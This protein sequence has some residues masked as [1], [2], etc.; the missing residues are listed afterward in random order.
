MIRNWLW[1][2][3]GPVEREG[4]NQVKMQGWEGR[5]KR[6]GAATGRGW[7]NVVFCNSPGVCPVFF[8]LYSGCLCAGHGKTTSDQD[9]LR[10]SQQ[11]RAL[12]SPQTA[13]W[14][15]LF[16][17][18]YADT[19]TRVFCWESFN[20]SNHLGYLLSFPTQ[21][22]LPIVHWSRARL[23]TPCTKSKRYT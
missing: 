17:H 23:C 9:H 6:W 22:L 10:G 20:Q 21:K 18:G 1:D 4:E 5:E 11:R 16:V 14:L 15:G 12:C 19:N 7:D 3:S 8:I 13:I 2:K